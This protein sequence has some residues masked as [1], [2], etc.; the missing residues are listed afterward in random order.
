MSAGQLSYRLC[1]RDFDCE[2]CPLDAALHGHTSESPDDEGLGV[3]DRDVADFPDDRLYT[4]GHTW[5]Q[6]A[7]VPDGRQARFG[8]DAFAA[9]VV[10]R[11]VRVAWTDGLL[12]RG[13][14]ACR[15]DLGLGTLR[16]GA[17]VRGTLV[18]RNARLQDNPSRLVTA[19]YAEG[20]LAD[21]V[22]AERDP[23]QGLL[24]S[25][26]ARAQAR[27]DLQRL[28]R[29]VATQVLAE[30]AGRIG[31]TLADGGELLTD[32]RQMLGGSTYLPIVQEL[33]H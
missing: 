11:C 2:H 18:N 33:I 16:I 12:T 4:S 19:P 21:L 23:A 29:R 3:P 26:V 25:K 1:D 24:T 10:G 14:T 32:L 15:V 30:D 22:V 31:P 5:I 6:F 17:P 9:A 13:A 27:F 7:D 28:R 20:W 8:V